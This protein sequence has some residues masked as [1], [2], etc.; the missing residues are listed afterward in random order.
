[1]DVASGE[2]RFRK[3]ASDPADPAEAVL[4]GLDQI[5]AD[6]G[7]TGQQVGF[8]G[9]GTT[10]ATNAVLDGKLGQAA[11]LVTA[12]FRDVLEL[13]R[14]RRPHL[15]NL[16]IAKPRPPMPPDGRVGGSRADQRGW[17]DNFFS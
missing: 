1:V 13:A 9:L 10:L 11:M 17:G 3:V 2:Y 12:G 15:Y 6:A 14:Q 7:I 5:L 16:D 8:V 4:R